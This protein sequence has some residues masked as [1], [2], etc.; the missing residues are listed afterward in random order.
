VAV[1]AS[2]DGQPNDGQPG[3]NENLGPDLEGVRGHTRQDDL[4]GD[5]RGN[6]LFLGFFGPRDAAGGTAAG[7][8]GDDRIGGGA[9]RNVLKGGAGN[10]LI[11]STVGQNLVFG[12]AGN[13]TV[14]SW[15]GDVD[16]IDG[17]TGY[18]RVFA[19]QFDRIT[20]VERAG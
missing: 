6:L 2:F 1:H 14:W 15:D 8:G 7:A 18:D 9:G 4:R 17:G 12:G 10:D 11:D 20:Q 5:E 19:N 16:R 13:D 3:E